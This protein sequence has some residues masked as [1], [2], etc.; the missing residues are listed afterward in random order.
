MVSQGKFHFS[1]FGSL[2]E[3]KINFLKE[4][5]L[6]SVSSFIIL[7]GSVMPFGKM[8]IINFHCNREEEFSNRRRQFDLY[9]T[10]YAYNR[11]LPFILCVTSAIETLLN[12]AVALLHTF[13]IHDWLFQ[14]QQFSNFEFSETFHST[15][16]SEL[17]RYL[18]MVIG[19]RG[20]ECNFREI[21]FCNYYVNSTKF[22]CS[23]D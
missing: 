21:Y 19:N 12:N 22:I 14:Q 15:W 7:S 9:N 11:F 16:L 4:C 23:S 10:T 3:A 18:R 1:V 6:V 2:Y 13:I 5:S 20:V 8:N 17:S